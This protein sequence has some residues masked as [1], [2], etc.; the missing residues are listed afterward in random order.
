MSS[1]EVHMETVNTIRNT[2][3]SALLENIAIEIMDKNIDVRLEEKLLM[4]IADNIYTP[5]YIL[6]MLADYH[7]VDVRSSVA[8][9]M[10]KSHSTAVKLSN[11]CEKDVC[12]IIR[13]YYG[14]L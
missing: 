5:Q 6:D 2:G 4:H 7:D 11:D 3:D 10:S 1:F 12:D 13:A 14:D 9:N 8:G